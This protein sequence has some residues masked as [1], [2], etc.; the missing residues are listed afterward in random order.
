[1]ACLLA[2]AT[3]AARIDGIGLETVD[4]RPALAVAHSGERP[5]VRV[6][7]A[8][9]RL[10]LLFAEATLAPSFPGAQFSWR[11]ERATG[12]LFTQ[13]DVARIAE[14]VR[15]RF[16]V[17]E[18]VPV[19]LHREARR[20]LIVF[21]PVRSADAGASGRS[22]LPEGARGLASLAPA[23]SAAR[24]R[25][26]AVR[27]M[28]IDSRLALRVLATQPLA[29]ASVRREGEDVV[30]SIVADVPD[31]FPEPEA[32]A[33]LERIVV[34]GRPGGASV[35]VKVPPEV[36][37]EVRRE[38][39]VLTVLF[40]EEAG[41]SVEPPNALYP[42]LF[43]GGAA[44]PAADLDAEPTKPTDTSPDGLNFGSLNLK[45]SAQVGYSDADVSVLDSPTPVRDRYFVAEPRVELNLPLSHGHLRGSYGM[46]FRSGS[47]ITEVN[48]VSH[49][50]D[51]TVELPIGGRSLVR[52]NDH[53]A[54]GVLE[55]NEVDPGR[56][57]FFDLGRFRRN[58][59]GLGADVSLGSRLSLV[60]GA[61]HNVVDFLE[62]SG[63]FSYEESSV[64]GGLGIELNDRLQGTVSYSYYQM[65]RPPERPEAEATAHSIGFQ[66]R[67][68][69][70]ALT[71]AQLG[72]GYR[73]QENPNAGAGGRLYTGLTA[74]G[75]VTREISPTTS[76]TL[77]VNRAVE[78]SA[79]EENGFYVTTAVLADARFQAPFSIAMHAGAAYQWNDYR[80][81]AAAIGAPRE[82]T[83]F[84][85]TLGAGRTLGRKAFFRA[86][87]RREHRSSNIQSF[88]ETWDTLLLQIGLGFFGAAPR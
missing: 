52:A 80:T 41:A 25:L 16:E 88:H 18:D 30:V 7:R 56:E 73:R 13:V 17:A 71:T 4:T 37:F 54:V 69:I 8:G 24:P 76:V 27:T 44:A 62:P 66:L 2:L 61:E 1:M 36:P 39:A 74:L 65:P 40:G 23:D 49:F 47:S 72:V 70:S 63:F 58:D 46:R 12:A 81:D 87:Y 20:A 53:F 84:S 22:L 45:P 6:T 42:L 38:A 86:D 10:T 21:R 34:L 82:D 26:L 32:V 67:G 75:S 57:Y 35:F 83:I 43:P 19:E 64:N 5:T 78:P 77:G 79:F 9:R 51:G 3:T 59:V 50:F 55:T 85:W 48:G 29:G 31:D 15:V 14:G 33:P 28:T 68:T 60:L 11:P